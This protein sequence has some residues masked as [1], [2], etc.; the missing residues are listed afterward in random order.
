MIKI[1]PTLIIKTPDIKQNVYLKYSKSGQDFLGKGRL[2][3]IS[4]YDPNCFWMFEKP[5]DE[6]PKDTILIVQNE[7]SSITE[8]PNLDLTKGIMLER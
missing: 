8:Y 7:D 4:R 6:Y 3:E 2:S 1:K 5:I